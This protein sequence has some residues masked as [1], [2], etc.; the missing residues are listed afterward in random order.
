[1]PSLLWQSER[2]GG[3]SLLTEPDRCSLLDSQPRL[4]FDSC[5]DFRVV[6]IDS[7]SFFSLLL[8]LLVQ[9]WRGGGDLFE[10]LLHETSLSTWSLIVSKLCTMVS[11]KSVTLIRRNFIKILQ[12]NLL[13]CSEDGKVNARRRMSVGVVWRGPV[14][15]VIFFSAFM[16]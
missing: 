1:M 14:Y 3:L 10:N 2:V 8:L 15:A 13:I 9:L 16:L 6:R 4:P 11:L 7:A 12:L 5:F